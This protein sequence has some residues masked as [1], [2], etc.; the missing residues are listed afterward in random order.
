MEGLNNSVSKSRLNNRHST[1][2]RD[3]LKEFSLII[4]TS[5][6]L[7]LLV[8]ALTSLLLPSPIDEGYDKAIQIGVISLLILASLYLIWRVIAVRSIS[9]FAWFEIIYNARDGEILPFMFES[10]FLPQDTA[11]QAFGALSSVKPPII[12]L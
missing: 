9:R 7:A 3:R 12:L 2:I 5:V 4:A 8:S 6:L 1:D 10:A 11:R